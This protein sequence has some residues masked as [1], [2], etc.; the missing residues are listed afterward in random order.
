MKKLLLFFLV[1]TALAS[2]SWAQQVVTGTVKSGDDGI[3]L[4]GVAIV[5]VGTTQGTVSDGSGN[6][7]LEVPAG[8]RLKFSYVGYQ[9]QEIDVGSQ[10]VINISLAA[11]V[12]QLGEIVVTALG[13]EKDTKSLGYSVTS[14]QGES[15]TEA[16]ENNL[17]NALEG[18][19]AGVNVSKNAGGP[20]G[21][22]RVIIRGNKTLLGGNQPLYV[23]DGIPLDNSGFGQAGMWG[24]RDEGDGM[25][26]IN[27]D[28]IESITVLKGAN[29]AALYGSRAANGVINIV[30]KKGSSRKG[31]GVEFNSNFVMER[32]NDLTDFQR[33]FGQG[34]NVLS[35]PNDPNSPRIAVAPRTQS[36]AYN[37]GTS[38]W[39]PKLGSVPSAIQFDGVTRPYTDQGDNWPKYFET[40]KQWTNSLA[41]SGG[42]ES[43]SFRFAFS[44]LR[45]SSVIPNAGFDRQ[46]LSLSANSRFGKNLVLNAKILYSHEYAKNRPYLSDSPANGILSMY[47]I[48]SNI[49]V[50]NYKGDPDKL[51]AIPA[52]QD[53]ASLTLWGK[54]AGEEFQQANN[55][56]H[57]NPW[58]TA[59]QFDNDDW[60]DRIIASGQI[61]Y[62]FTEWLF[63][64]GR[65]GM[66]W[67]TRRET[68]LVPQGTGYQRGGSIGIGENRVKELN[69]EWTLGFDKTFG[70]ISVNAFVG[71]NM[72]R[73]SNERM[74]LSGNGFNVPFFNAINNSIT[75][76]WGYGFGQYGI[77]SLFGSAEVGYNGFLFLTATARNDWFSVLNDDFNSILYPSVGASFVFSEA[78]DLPDAISFGKLRASWAQ[79]G[80]ATV[81]AYGTNLTYSLNGNSH[82]GYTM[83]SF[84]SA[85]GNNGTIP[86][87]EI[88]PLTSTEIEFGIDMRFLDNRL[89][90]DFTYYSQKTTEDILN[91]TISRASGFGATRVNVG[92]LQNKGIEVLLTATPVRSA[93]TWDVSL[94][95]AKNNNKVVS[96][97]EGV[98]ELVLEEPRARVAFIKH[99][100]GQP[101]GVIVGREQMTDD[102]GTPVFY[103]NGRMKGTA[104]MVILGNGV[105][106]LTGGFEN[107]FTF[108]NFN[109][110]ALLD[111]KFGGD[112]LSGTN[113]RMT[114]SGKHKQTLQGRAGEAPLHVTGVYQSGTAGDGSPIYTAIDRDLLPNEAQSYWGNAGGSDAD[115][116]ASM[117]MYDASFAKLRH[118]TLGYNFPRTM[119]GK[120][121]FQN[122]SLSFVARNLAILYR[123]VDNIDP[124]SGYTTSNSQGFDYFGMPATRTYGFNLRATF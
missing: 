25:S 95:L 22:S 12:T 30:T 54:I 77:N 82:L 56:W 94:N 61:R 5:I 97:I 118:V 106:D 96:L 72:M 2:Y 124:E 41:L 49:D 78:F 115:G 46:N 75:R 62:N 65:I 60:R 114:S 4:P 29:A 84:S 34:G 47:Y 119:L 91:A 83:A 8:S 89:G 23:I 108:K 35:D 44:D 79:V 36:E 103:Q 110:S 111:F 88:Q 87:P 55:N 38:N 70:S 57:Q 53:Q 116:I 122:L 121:P 33:D 43:Q 18:R 99:I 68:D 7:R 13:I 14:V 105:P 59:Y 117:F 101:F 64:Q 58:W 86:N 32:V 50:N 76:N 24:G 123:N 90:I 11:D 73:S 51:G 69:A 102:T 19:V 92:E 6:Y 66:D 71:G 52:T 63:A 9:S 113:M 3:A 85:F 27:P 16:R 10:S 28:D 80:G 42:S 112:V 15:F 104:D 26:S 120:T 31:I 109:L 37:W 48:P 17:A 1:M 39:G 20:A 98:D 100:V 81:G 21:S 45:G 67:Y 40:G 107:S 74:S 93:L